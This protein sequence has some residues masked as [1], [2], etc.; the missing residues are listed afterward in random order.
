[1]YLVNFFFIVLLSLIAVNHAFININAK[2][3]F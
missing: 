2:Q 3:L 1:M